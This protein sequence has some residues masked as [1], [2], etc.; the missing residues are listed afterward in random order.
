I[1]LGDER[2]IEKTLEACGKVARR[3]A[4]LAPDTILIISPHAAY[5]ADWIYIAE[6]TSAQGSFAQFGAPLNSFR[7]H[8]DTDFVE[9]LVVEAEA[10]AVSAGCVSGAARPL[11][12]GVMVPLYLIEEEYALAS[13]RFVVIGGS[14]LA[15]EELI[16]FGRCIARVAEKSAKDIVLV[17][18][19]DLSHKLKADGPYGFDPAGPLFDE[20]F[21][22]VVCSG[23]PLDFASL[24]K[25]LCEDAAECGLSGF[26][27]LAGAIEETA[28]LS[29][30]EFSSELLSLEGPFGVGYGVA[31]FERKKGE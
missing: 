20:A 29:G 31:A 13:S 11:D 4:S 25:D 12:H 2:K 7:V 18:S 21:G 8:Y 30:D 10:Q 6:G 19:G 28:K 26:T 5:Y 14:G 16:A 15:P 27:M 1:G 22:R 24:D 9:A 23:K 17:A 3:I